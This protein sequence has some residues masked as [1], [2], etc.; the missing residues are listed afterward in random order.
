MSCPKKEIPFE[1]LKIK[2]LK[3]LI[4]EGKTRKEMAEYYGVSRWTIDRRM[5][6]LDNL[7]KQDKEKK[8]KGSK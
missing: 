8:T 1:D 6:E 3:T 2:G 4:K 7:T 5:I